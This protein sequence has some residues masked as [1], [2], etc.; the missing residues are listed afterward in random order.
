MMYVLSVWGNLTMY[1]YI[2]S[3]HTL[4][5]SYHFIIIPQAE[6][7]KKPAGQRQTLGP[8]FQYDSKG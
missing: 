8:I 2:Q 1:I 4:E 3:S 5:L 7:Q 6:K